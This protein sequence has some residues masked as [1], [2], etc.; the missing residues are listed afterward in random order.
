M[1]DPVLSIAA[2]IQLRCAKRGVVKFSVATGRLSE[3][4]THKSDIGTPRK[5]KKRSTAP[6]NPLTIKQHK[7]SIGA[8][9]KESTTAGDIHNHRE[10]VKRDAVMRRVGRE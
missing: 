5:G 9:R 3:V 7:N 2:S 6:T 4:G 8:L 1:R 10:G